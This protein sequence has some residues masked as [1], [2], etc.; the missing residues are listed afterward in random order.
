MSFFQERVGTRT[1]TNQ[2]TPAEVLQLR[3]SGPLSRAAEGFMIEIDGR[4]LDKA[5]LAEYRTALWYLFEFVGCDAPCCEL[6]AETPARFLDW[7][8]KTP[9]AP[10]MSKTR[11]KSFS[12]SAVSAFF[13]WPPRKKCTEKFRC[14]QTVGKYWRH[15]APFFVYLGM[16]TDLKNA[17]PDTARISTCRRP[18]CRCGRR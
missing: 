14:E 17:A 3:L 13:R 8:R 4:E 7:L 16:P 2:P 15:I 12:A 1:S 9:I 6:V 11:P 5:T 10:R 18:W